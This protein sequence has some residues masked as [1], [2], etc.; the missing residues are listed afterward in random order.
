[1]RTSGELFSQVVRNLDIGENSLRLWVKQADIAEGKG[2]E[3]ALI[4]AE[5]EEMRQLKR[6]LKQVTM[7]RDFLKKAALGSMGQG[8]RTASRMCR[9]N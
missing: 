6:Q 1:M 9:P 5:K 7:E 4:T 3:G 2:P 8:N